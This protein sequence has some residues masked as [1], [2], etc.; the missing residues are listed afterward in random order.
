MAVGCSVTHNSVVSA[1][2]SPFLEAAA[3]AAD[4]L[5]QPKVE[6]QWGDASVLEYFSVSGLAGH[7][8]RGLTTVDTYLGSPPATEEPISAGEYFTR[9]TS[10]DI[11]A[12]GNQAIRTRGEEMAANGPTAVANAA[13][14]TYERLSVRLPDENPKRHLRVAGDLVMTLDDYLRTRVVELVIHGDDLASSV[15]LAFGPVSSDL[16]TTAISTLVEVARVRHGDMAV[17]RGL[18]RRERDSVQALRVF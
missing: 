6:Q 2:F 13:R 16:A 15:G 14:A 1:T 17:L 12:P 4:L 7:L 10:S 18:T 5:A 9:L 3:A 11:D 8:L